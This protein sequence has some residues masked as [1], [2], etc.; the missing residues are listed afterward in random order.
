MNPE[1]IWI[2]LYLAA[3]DQAG[4]NSHTLFYSRIDGCLLPSK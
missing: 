1:S 4:S 3:L 2:W